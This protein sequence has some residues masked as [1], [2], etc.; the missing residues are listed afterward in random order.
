MNK[1]QATHFLK[2]LFKELWD[3]PAPEKVAN[4]Y[5]KNMTCYVGKQRI[6]FS[7]IKNRAI[8]A[9]KHFSK[10]TTKILDVIAEDNKI[11]F[12]VNQIITPK[13]GIK[14]LVYNNI[15]IYHLRNGKI[16]KMWFLTDQE[17]NYLEKP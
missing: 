17:L 16:A 3:H 13:D 4:F 12:R 1:K 10:V 15:I 5:H 11:A 6:T 14:N 7:D 9:H 8:F 2:R